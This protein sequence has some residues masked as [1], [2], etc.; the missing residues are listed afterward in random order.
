[1]TE[2]VQ[3]RRMIVS[4]QF[5]DGSFLELILTGAVPTSEALDMLDD[6]LA[7]KRRELAGLGPSGR[8]G[9]AIDPPP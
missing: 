9:R 1:M 8:A 3:R 6:L 5:E 4:W 7:E 2:P